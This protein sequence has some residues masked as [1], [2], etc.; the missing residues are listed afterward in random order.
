MPAPLQLLI[1]VAGMTFRGLVGIAPFFAVVTLAEMFCPCTGPRPSLRSRLTALAWLATQFF[2]GFAVVRMEMPL[3]ARIDVRP[4]FP[5][6]GWP[7]LAGQVAGALA[8]LIF[9]DFA[10][11]WFHRFEH[12]FLWRL[13][14]V[15]HSPRE[16]S[17]V[18]GIH[19]WSEGPL[20]ALFWAVPVG[21]LAPYPFSAP[22]VGEFWVLW[23]AFIHSPLRLRVP[24]LID[25]PRH[26]IHHSLEGRHFNKNFGIL[27]P[28]WDKLFGTFYDPEPGEIPATGV[29]D[30]G[31][32][33]NLGEAVFTPGGWRWMISAIPWP[34]QPASQDEPL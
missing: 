33:A 24:G 22:A 28:W 23:G 29:P 11:Y 1:A 32:I 7:G 10:Y 17:V 31:P 8:A 4:L 30:H 5:S 3:L 26:R 2:V 21:V 13:H 20:Q 6:W 27:M 19:H 16:L 14:A 25:G 9:A 12:R 18:A 34:R 15:H